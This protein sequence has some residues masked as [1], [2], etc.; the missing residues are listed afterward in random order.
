MSASQTG[1]KSVVLSVGLSAV[2]LYLAAHAV[3]GQQ[4][5][6]SYMTLQERH[7][8]LV[9]EQDEL[10]RERADLD[11]RLKAMGSGRIDK[12]ALEE[13]ARQQFA[14]AH[15]DEIVFELEQ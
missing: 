11:V 2:I 3:T 15:P 1:H 8:M 12:D 10:A 14:A 7:E 5:L 4:G 9:A 6:I 13:L